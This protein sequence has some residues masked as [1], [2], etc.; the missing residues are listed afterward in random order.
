MVTYLTL[1][2]WTEQGVSKMNDSPKRAEDFAKVAE[3]A[4]ARV[5]QFGWLVGKYDGFFI[6]EAPDET[7]GVAVVAHLAKLGNIHTRTLRS[8]DAGEMRQI[9]GKVK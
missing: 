8:F 9:L 3:Q 7:T 6:L 1:W 5:R 2:N 4:G